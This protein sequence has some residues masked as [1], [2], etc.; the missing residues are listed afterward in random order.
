MGNCLGGPHFSD[1]CS[2]RRMAV[3][4]I[5]RIGTSESLAS[6]SYVRGASKRWTLQEVKGP[7]N[8]KAPEDV[9]KVARDIKGKLQVTA[10]SSQK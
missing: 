10:V 4:S 9:I 7:N 3:Y 1:A 2:S 5:R 6:A 8:S